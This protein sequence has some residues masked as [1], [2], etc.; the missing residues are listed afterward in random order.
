M[1]RIIID[2]MTDF[3]ATGKGYSILDDEVQQM[4]TF[5]SVD[6]ARYFVIDDGSRVLGCGGV[7]QLEGGDSDTCELR[8]MYFLPELR[9]QGMG[10]KLILHCLEAAKELGYRQCYLETLESM[11]Q[12]R[13]LYRKVG[14]KKVD[15]S[16]GNTGHSK[17]NSWM[18]LDLEGSG[19]GT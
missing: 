15:H 2:V 14:F 18:L 7:A 13:A 19:R 4:S 1:S 11:H 5:Y 3:G 17:C 12:A 8:K 9:G 10:M 6:G 16:M